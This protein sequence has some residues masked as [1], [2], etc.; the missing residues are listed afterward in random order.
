MITPGGVVTE[1]KKSIKGGPWGVGRGAGNTIW[2][3]IV[4]GGKLARLT[5]TP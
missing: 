3:T 4:E 2:V 1:G 5:I